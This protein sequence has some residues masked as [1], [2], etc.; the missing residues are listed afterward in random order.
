MTQPSE[1]SEDWIEDKGQGF[2]MCLKDGFTTNSKRGMNIHKA[3]IHPDI[4]DLF[5]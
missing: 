3:K 5:R 2:F 1:G 4:E